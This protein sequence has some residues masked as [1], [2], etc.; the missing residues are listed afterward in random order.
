MIK[1]KIFKI[2][3]LGLALKVTDNAFER[4]NVL[5]AALEKL[6]PQ[7]QILDIDHRADIYSLGLILY[8]ILYGRHPYYE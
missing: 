3:D 2:G 6:Q 5:Y 8:E 4:G 1:D 7:A